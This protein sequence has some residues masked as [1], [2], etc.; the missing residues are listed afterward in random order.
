MYEISGNH[1]RPQRFW[2]HFNKDKSKLV[3]HTRQLSADVLEELLK[4]MALQIRQ[5][6]IKKALNCDI[7]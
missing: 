7:N 1:L 5:F 3:I 4:G 6:L 2:T